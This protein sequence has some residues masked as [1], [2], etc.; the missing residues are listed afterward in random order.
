VREDDFVFRWALDVQNWLLTGE[1][2][3]Q[4]GLCVVPPAEVVLPDGFWF[5]VR[6]ELSGR[7][8][9]MTICNRN[10]LN[11]EERLSHCSLYS[12]DLDY[13]IIN[14]C[15]SVAAYALFWLDA[16]TQVGLIEPMRTENEYQRKGLGTAL[17][18]QGI[19]CLQAG[20]AE[21][22]KVSY[23]EGNEAA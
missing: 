9:P 4:T 6:T 17:V 22:I 2:T 5:E 18:C 7:Q 8:H 3:V 15:G 19:R 14:S 21:T 10:P 12:S 1:A 11:M 23:K 16:K 20:G 13:S